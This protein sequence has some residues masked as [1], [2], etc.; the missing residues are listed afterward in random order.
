MVI[1]VSSRNSEFDSCCRKEDVMSDL[2]KGMLDKFK[3]L[4]SQVQPH[5]TEPSVARVTC[6]Q[7]EETLMSYVQGL[8]QAI[9]ESTD[10]EL[11]P[12]EVETR[13]K[14]YIQYLIVARIRYVNGEKLPFPPTD[15]VWIV[16]AFINVVLAQ[17]GRI[18]DPN[19]GIVLQPVLT[20]EQAHYEAWTAEKISREARW[21]RTR[22]DV[23][24]I[25]YAN[26]LPKSRDGNHEMMTLQ[27]INDKV[28]GE[29][30]SHPGVH[31]LIAGFLGLKFM[32]NV[33]AP[34]VEYATIKSVRRMLAR[35]VDYEH[36][37]GS[38]HR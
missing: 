5:T 28:M 38:S 19:L 25:E 37:A 29:D 7:A 15:R 20:Q 10:R 12:S 24:N 21:L 35:V 3:D 17:I 4:V 1:P 14:E 8:A 13:C 22:L 33:L 30:G 32:E 16:P 11:D 31:A 9:V 27:V 23:A 6:D 36:N 26:G 18:D 2:V 34:R